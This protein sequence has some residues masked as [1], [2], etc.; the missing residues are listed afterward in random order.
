MSSVQSLSISG[1]KSIRELLNFPLTNL[2][3]LIGANGA[4]KSNF[5]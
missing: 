1:Y 3:V 2:N 5:I 4:G